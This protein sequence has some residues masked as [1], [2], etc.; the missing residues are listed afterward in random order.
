[1]VLFIEFFGGDKADHK[2]KKKEV[3]RNLVES[4]KNQLLVGFVLIKV[5]LFAGTGNPGTKTRAFF[6]PESN[7]PRLGPH[8]L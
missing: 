4:D 8:L 2:K 7:S 5:L 3:Q 1:M 6:A